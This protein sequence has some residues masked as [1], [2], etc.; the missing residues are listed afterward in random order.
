P[1]L[2]GKHAI[3]GKVTEGLDVVQA[4][5]KVRTGSADRPVDDVVMEKVTVSD[6]G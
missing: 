1:W 3:F 2:D 5:G 4:I 6:G